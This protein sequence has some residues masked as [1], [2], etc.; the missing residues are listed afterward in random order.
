[1]RAITIRPIVLLDSDGPLSNFT[2]AWLDALY[3]ETG[4]R[5][6]PEEVDRWDIHKTAF[7]AEIAKKVY[8]AVIAEAGDV[9]AAI[10]ALK[11]RCI[12][13][14][15]KPGFCDAIQVQ[16]GAIE[17]VDRLRKIA[18][19][20]VVTS[21]WDSSPTWEFERKNW[22]KRHFDI[23]HHNVLQG[24]AKH[25]VFG[26]VFVD[27]KIDHVLEWS[28]RW[29]EGRAILFDMHHNRAAPTAIAEEHRGTWDT[30]IAHVEKLAS[31]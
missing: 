22:L 27:D 21:P 12:Q 19:V 25:L 16:P 5:H 28:K 18:D 13:H 30:V 11:S 29:P 6:T 10:Q 3:I 31:A 2:Q 20:Y 8:G 15:V 4:A 9:K 24:A 7:F 1:M 26:N 23:H 17:A 14:V